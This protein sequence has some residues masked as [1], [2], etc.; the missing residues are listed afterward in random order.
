MKKAGVFGLLALLAMALVFPLVIPDPTIASM[1]VFTLLFAAAATGWNIFSGY[2]GY[3]SLGHASFYGLGAY[4]LALACR[5]WHVPGGYLPFLFFPLAGLVAGVGAIPLGWIAL[6][7]RRHVFV[8]V[9]IALLFILQLLAYN[10][11]PLTNGSAGLYLPTPSWSED[12]FYLPFYYVA[13]FLALLALGVSWW[14]RHSKFGLG[15]LAIRDD[16]DRALSLGVKTEVYKLGAYVVSA[17]ITG[18]AGAFYAYFTGV[19]YPQFTFDPV[20]DISVALMT[21]LGGLGTLLGPIIGALLL[22]PAQQYITIQFGSNGMDLVLYGGLFLIIIYLLP[23]GIVPALR[24]RWAMWTAS[25]SNVKLVSVVTTTAE[26]DSG[27]T[28]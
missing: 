8:V 14:V 25:R 20:Y 6:S 15:L 2:T 1:A 22:E 11:K 24:R 28:H 16:E 17:V 23:D 12:V 18:M 5:V 3:I 4:T 26:Q 13:L 7:T 21:F 19:V 9:T 27:Q 10:L